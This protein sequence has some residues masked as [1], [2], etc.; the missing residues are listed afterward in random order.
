[1]RLL[2]DTNPMCYG[3]TATLLAILDQVDAECTVLTEGITA[4][5]VERDPRVAHT[6]P[7]QLK[8][9]HAVATI[10]GERSYD[11][12]LVVNNQSNLDV[13]AARGWPIFYV[14]ILFWYGAQK[15]SRPVWRLA[16]RSFVQTFEG[17]A[18]RLESMPREVRSKITRV[19]P[20][21]RSPP[22]GAQR[23]TL[24]NIGGARSR[25]VLPGR[26]SS[27]TR[28]VVS[29]VME[30]VDSLPPGP[31]HIAAG[32]EA[33]ASL[34]GMDLHERMSAS[35]LHNRD[36]L[37]TLGRAEL[38]IT[39]PGLNAVFEGLVAGVDLMFLPPQNASQVMQ[40]A[41]YERAEIVPPGLNLDALADGFHVPP[42]ME[43]EAELTQHVL[44]A[45]PRIR[46]EHVA[47]HLR[48]QLARQ[49]GLREARRRYMTTLGSPGG[50]EVAAAI[51]AWWEGRWS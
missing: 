40:L 43:D 42:Q 32:R 27:Y 36:Y 45:L 35:T 48:L 33:I 51:R 46:P 39:A 25:F 41:A 28:Q 9:P 20:I 5:L 18:E 19:G 1:M 6:L 23:G 11:A 31:I 34:E 22:R 15:A 50:P 12:V 2:C 38:L 37:A 4:E 24:V 44:A 16:T 3:S 30:I 14:D 13:Y 49:P 21:V 10:L 7:T 8:D 26:N 29:W 17:V 47:S